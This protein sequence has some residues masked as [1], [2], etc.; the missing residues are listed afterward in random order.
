VSKREQK[1]AVRS[2]EDSSQV[3]EKHPIA[4]DVGMTEK[5]NGDGKQIPAEGALDIEV[6]LHFLLLLES[7][8]GLWIQGIRD[9]IYEAAG[10]ME[11]PYART[12]LM[13]KLSQGL[14]V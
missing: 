11:N 5:G 3:S 7:M 4:G 2:F 6:A 10:K 13:D 8:E 14:T 1:Q 12:L 9:R